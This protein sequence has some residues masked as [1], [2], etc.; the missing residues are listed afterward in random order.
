[1]PVNGFL[2]L[3][4]AHIGMSG[5][6]QTS[7][8]II[9]ARARPDLCVAADRCRA[10]PCR[11]FRR[12]R[13]ARPGYQSRPVTRPPSPPNCSWPPAGSFRCR[14]AHP[15]RRPWCPRWRR[16][17]GPAVLGLAVARG[18]VAP[19]AT[20][21][22]ASHRSCSLLVVPLPALFR[23]PRCSAARSACHPPAR[24]GMTTAARSAS[25]ARMTTAINRSVPRGLGEA[26]RPHIALP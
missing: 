26:C 5:R 17:S 1:M 24:A 18:A 12:I 15:T 16:D 2:G 6:P 14:S 20:A 23:C 25:N 22:L 11:P 7:Q 9:E 4:R 8:E 21:A 3:A 13:R 10:G 19:R